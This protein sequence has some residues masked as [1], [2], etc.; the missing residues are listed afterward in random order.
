RDIMKI[1]GACVRELPDGSYSVEQRRL[2]QSIRRCEECVAA[3]N[4]LALMKKGRTRSEADDCPICQL[5]LPLGFKQSSFRVCCMKEVCDGCVLASQRRGMLDCPFCRA[6]TEMTDSQ[7]LAMIRKRVDAGNPEAIYYLGTHYEYG[8]HG[9]EKDVTRAVELYER[10][11]ELGAKEA[12]Y[13]IGVLYAQGEDVERDTAKAFRHFEAAAM[14]G[15]VSA[16]HIMISAKLGHEKS[17][18]MV[19]SAFMDGLATKADYAAALRGYQ[20]SI[21]EMTQS[22]VMF[23]PCHIN[24]NSAPTTLSDQVTVPGTAS[25]S[26]RGRNERARP[27]ALGA[28]SARGWLIDDGRPSDAA[29]LLPSRTGEER[30][31]LRGPRSPPSSF[32]P[33]PPPPVLP[34][35]PRGGRHC[36]GLREKSPPSARRS[37]DNGGFPLDRPASSGAGTRRGRRPQKSSG[38]VPRIPTRV[39]RLSSGRSGAVSSPPATRSSSGYSEGVGAPE[40]Y[41]PL[42]QRPQSE[43]PVMP[44]AAPGSSVVYGDPADIS[45]S[46]SSGTRV[47]PR[48]CCDRVLRCGLVAEHPGL[49]HEPE[50][51]GSRPALLPREDRLRGQISEACLKSLVCGACERELPEG[52]Y[53]VEQRR[54]RQSIRRCE[55]CVA[56]G[57]QLVLMKKGRTRSEGDDCPICQLPIPLDFKQSETRP[58][59]MTRVCKG[60]A[61]AA[62]KRGMWDCPFCRTPAPKTHSQVLVMVKKRVD[63][64]DPMAIYTLGNLYEYGR[65]GLEKDVT[66]AFE[67]YEHAAELGVKEAHF[68][69]G[70]LYEEGAEVEKDMAKAFRHYEAAAMCGHVSARHNLGCE[71]HEAENYDLALQHYLISAKLGADRSLLKVKTLFIDGLATKADYAAALRGH[72][73]ASEEM[74]SP[75]RD[76]AK[77]LL[78]FA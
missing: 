26:L 71:E 11:A 53:S 37:P 19:K 4:Q 3:G 76:V 72:Q 58:C 73:K 24:P 49:E 12:H 55:E 75:N 60:C 7:A 30:R 48:R 9:L 69:L 39:E 6:P 56:A 67:L 46:G 23:F 43:C 35:R 63:A 14:C 59:C 32:T 47:P 36:G 29:V 17:L 18:N 78:L 54:L 22:P 5:P 62:Q 40:S 66:R 45:P 16:R 44:A 10:A 77:V 74:S 68:S 15:H 41:D 20:N 28:L 33:P 70:V 65:L 25:S 31:R 52:S 38:L 64:G 61:L 51:A 34:Q 50:G 13:N 57:N 27:K 2:R 8:Q 21:K 42:R 1:C